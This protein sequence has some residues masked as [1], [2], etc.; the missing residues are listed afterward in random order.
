LPT[1]FFRGTQ[2]KQSIG[3]P[4]PLPRATAPFPYVMLLAPWSRAERPFREYEIA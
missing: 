3:L 1:S 4:S 2:N